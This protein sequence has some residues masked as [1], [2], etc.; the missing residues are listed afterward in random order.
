M[1]A[2]KEARN[3]FTTWEMTPVYAGAGVQPGTGDI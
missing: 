1:S 2:I 3:Y